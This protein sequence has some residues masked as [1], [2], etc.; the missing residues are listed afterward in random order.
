M[1]KLKAIQSPTN[2]RQRFK[3]AQKNRTLVHPLLPQPTRLEEEK[4]LKHLASRQDS[5]DSSEK[6][7]PLCRPCKPQSELENHSDSHTFVICADSQLGMTSLNEEWETE[8][9]YCRIAVSKINSLHPRPKFV[10]MCGD[11]VD[12]E[13]SF[14]YNN[15]KALKNFE[16]EDCETIQQKQFDDFQE[17][18]DQLHPD[19]A[20]VC[21]CGNHDIGRYFF[22]WVWTD[23]CNQVTK[24][25][26]SVGRKSSNTGVN[27][28]VQECIWRW[29]PCILGQ[30]NLQCCPEQCFIHKSR[31]RSRYVQRATR[32]ARRTVDLR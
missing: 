18:F 14:Y 29:I 11:I 31:W 22:I 27:R 1:S 5:G 8:L 13:Q 26:I 4:H 16:L 19:I 24:F 7:I 2:H 6:T 25:M 23:K 17:T 30:W 21:L 3:E 20:I 9:Q 28:N 12:M 15:P 32:M 10:S